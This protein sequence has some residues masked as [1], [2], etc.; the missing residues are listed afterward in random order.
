[1]YGLYRRPAAGGERQ[2]LDDEVLNRT[3][4]MSMQAEKSSKRIDTGYAALDRSLF[5]LNLA[6]TK[7]V[8]LLT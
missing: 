4:P 8:L 7:V 1:L 5:Y 6:L 3:A 2:G